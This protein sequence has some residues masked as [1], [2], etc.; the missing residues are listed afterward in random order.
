[1]S[2]DY[3]KNKADSYDRD[4]NKHDTLDKIAGLITS[5]VQLQPDMCLMDFG[6]GT[7]LLLERVAPY[8][9][10]ITA[11]DMSASMNQ[12]LK[13]KIEQIG[14][15]VE[16]VEADL[17]TTIIDQKFDGIISSMTMHH[18]EDIKAIFD[19]FYAMLSEGGFIAIADLDSED[20]NFHD[21]DTGVYHQGF[22]RDQLSNVI[23]LTQFRNVKIQSASTIKKTHGDYSLFLLSAVK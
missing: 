23:S 20:G 1:M 10:K 22:C 18:V 14:C 3:F 8:V 5:T 7:G 21:E 19:K 6:S 11:V 2:K 4:S 15:E 12:Q 16:I 13:Q 17:T 9:K